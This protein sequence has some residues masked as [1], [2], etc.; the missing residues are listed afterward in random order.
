[1]ITKVLLH[2]DVSGGE[3]PQQRVTSHRVMPSYSTIRLFLNSCFG[4]RNYKSMATKVTFLDKDEILGALVRA[5]A[6]QVAGF[7][8]VGGM[9]AEYLNRKGFY[10]F[11]LSEPQANR[12]KSLIK[13][14]I[15]DRLQQLIQITDD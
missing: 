3:F 14:Y 8:V 2:N 1:M 12:F 9:N 10:L 6:V 4:R 11:Q 7:Q 13:S 5:L 15:P